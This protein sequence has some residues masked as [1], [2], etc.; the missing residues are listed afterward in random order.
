MFDTSA[1]GRGFPDLLV[2]VPA[3]RKLVLIELKNSEASHP[4]ITPMQMEFQQ[5][6]QGYPIFTFD[7][8]EDAFDLIVGPRPQTR[9]VPT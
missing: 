4:K 7:R 9:K 6:F 1:M 2:G 3:L 8:A 5:L